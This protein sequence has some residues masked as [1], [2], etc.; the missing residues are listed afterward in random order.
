MSSKIVGVLLYP[1]C[2]YLEVARAVELLAERFQVLHFTPE[3]S[4]HAGADD[5]MIQPDGSYTALETTDVACVLVPGGNPDSIIPEQ[6]ATAALNRAAAN[7]ALM[8]GICAGNLVLASAGLLRGK[9]ATHNYT[10]EY[11]PSEKLEA[12]APFLGRQRV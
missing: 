11:A 9:R 1:G 5:V 4:V 8:A 12:T 6:K 3:G 7:G 10:A 2:V